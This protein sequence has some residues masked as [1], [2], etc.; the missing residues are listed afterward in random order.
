MAIVGFM[1]DEEGNVGMVDLFKSAEVSMDDEALRLILKSPKW[2]P[3]LREG[4][5]IK[6]DKL[7]PIV[8]KISETIESS[9]F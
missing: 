4:K 3:G 7:Q 8:F 9:V 2:K 1:V 5:K 6:T